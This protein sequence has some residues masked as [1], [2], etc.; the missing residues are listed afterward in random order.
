MHLKKLSLINFKNFQQANVEFSAKFNCFSGNNGSGKTNLLDAI[1]YLSFCKSFSNPSDSNNIL[2]NMDMFMI[3]GFYQNLGQD[4]ELFCA[5]KRNQRKIFKQNKKE[6]E[7]LSDHIG[8]YPLVMISPNDTQLILGGS[9]ERRKFLDSVVSQYN[10]EYLDHLIRYNRALSQRNALLKQFADRGNFDRESLEIWDDQLIQH[11]NFIYTKRLE[12]FQAF[13]P[14]FQQYYQQ[15]SGGNEETGIAYLSSL[16]D[17]D[18]QDQ[19]SESRQKDLY[20]QYTTTGT[21]KDDL[22]FLIH[23]VSVKKFGS[24]GQQKTFLISL[25]LAQYA[26]TR[27]IKGFNPVLLFDDIFDKLDDSRVKE[28]MQLVNNEEFGQV[29]V[30][31]TNSE[32]LL[33]M[34]NTINA[35][36]W[37]FLVDKGTIQNT[38]KLK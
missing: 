37:H 20:A 38:H 26:F 30:T 36:S 14:V 9:E 28:L 11:G 18:F 5:F 15:L 17:K 13:M 3:Q 31:D 21:H 29:F 6:Y 16:H 10:H 7:R 1:Y 12:F 19:L 4:Q 22:E 24:Q 27:D 8:Q 2:F 25:K 35:E 33:Q 32:R 23:Q 34:L